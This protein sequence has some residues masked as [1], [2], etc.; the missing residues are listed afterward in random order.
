[1]STTDASP[2]RVNPLV[3]FAR[4][5]KLSHTIFAL[6]FALSAVWLV[7]LQQ[8][9][10]W[11]QW[12]WI[13]VAMVGARTSA[14]GFNR[15]VDRK[16]D[17]ANPRTAGRALP[18][19]EVPVGLAWAL[20]LGSAALMV[21][22]AGMLHLHALVASPLVLAIIWGYSLA[23]R[24]TA[25]CH[26]ILGLAL[27][28]APLAAWLALT[29]TVQAPALVLAGIV[30]TFG[31]AVDANV[32]IFERIREE[33]REG[34]TLIA[35]IGDGFKN[36]YSAIIDANVTTILTAMVL[37]YF[38]LGPIKGFAV[39]LIIGV[40]SSLFTAVLVGKLMIDYW[41]GRNKSISFE[42]SVSKNAFSNLN[43]DWLGKRKIAYIFSGSFLVIGLIAIVTKGFELGVDFK[44][45]YSYNVSFA[46]ED[47]TDIES[48]RNA[49][50]TAFE[51]NTPIVKA[52]DTDNTFNV[53]TDYMID[54]DSDEAAE[55]VMAQLFAGVNAEAGGDLNFENFK[56][57][58][59]SGTYVASSSKVGATIA[60]D[61][62]DSAFYATIFALLL[63]FLYIFIRFSK[64]QYSL[65][66][67]VALFHDV[68]FV[69]GFF[70]L[71]HGIL[72]FSMEIDQA[73]IAALLTVIGYS[74][75]DTVV[76]FD[77]IR[78]YMN[79]YINKDKHE[80]VNMAVNNT[81]S[82]TIITSLTTLFVVFI[83]FVFGGASIKGFA[84]A[85]L[86]GILVGTYSSIFIATPVM[87]D[88]TSDFTP[89]GGGS[90][91]TRK[92]FS[93]ALEKAR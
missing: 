78:E 13:L 23:K 2:A 66:A 36:S 69:L 76:V 17:A 60:D 39:V 5:I 56:N 24:V 90:R 72:P 14:M 4:D 70:A 85:L 18:A 82:R 64:W 67:V 55:K 28:C 43:I 49:L 59:G 26:L 42:T 87:A 71:F 83:L 65:G 86:L 92:S 1:M 3:A 50:T 21:F 30:L 37:A 84:F 62:Q 16:I 52:V 40:L 77:R 79:L 44:G 12:A 32:I 15:L 45:G 63:I 34:K 25:L 10:T 19:G 80:V 57:P 29:G 31:M 11:V 68:L 73:L 46:A 47:N 75:N 9:S 48:L 51:G 89:K 7:H 8:G 27:G 81:V 54:D 61:I 33:L 38:G 93:K 74:I 41:T 53:V 91:K 20:T 88:L 6:P 35:A 58:D 22:A